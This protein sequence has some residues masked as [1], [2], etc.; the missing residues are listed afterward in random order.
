MKKKWIRFAMCG[1]VCTMLLGGLWASA[2]EKEISENLS[3]LELQN[4]DQ[5]QYADVMEAAPYA[6]MDLNAVQ[7][8]ATKEKILEARNTIIFNQSWTAEEGLEAGVIDLETGEWIEQAPYFY[9]I[10]PA[11]WEIPN[12]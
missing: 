8:T 9:D 6:Y 10:F 2:A 1:C 5:E 12:K 3:T 7:D 4:L 11:D